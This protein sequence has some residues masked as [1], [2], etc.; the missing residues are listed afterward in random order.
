MTELE[1]P[2]DATEEEAAELVMEFVAVGDEIEVKGEEMTETAGDGRARASGRVTR[3]EPGY[4]QID[5]D[6]PVGESVRYDEIHL[7]TRIDT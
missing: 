5:G 6:S 1:I 2:P 4:L 7:V 3:I